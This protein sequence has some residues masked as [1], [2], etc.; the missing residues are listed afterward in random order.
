MRAQVEREEEGR[1][2]LSRHLMQSSGIFIIGLCDGE[3]RQGQMDGRGGRSLKR[4]YED[5]TELERQLVQGE[6]KFDSESQKVSPLGNREPHLKPPRHRE[7]PDS[8]IN[9]N[10]QD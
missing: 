3:G 7:H 9:A 4:R 10:K 6:D 5:N 8:N 1:V 2:P